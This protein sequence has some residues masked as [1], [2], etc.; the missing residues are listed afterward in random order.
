M[1]GLTMVVAVGSHRR[2]LWRRL[3]AGYL[4]FLVPIPTA[5]GGRR[6]VGGAS[7]IAVKGIESRR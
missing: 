2:L 6:P 3:P 4:E 5:A 7:A 1:I